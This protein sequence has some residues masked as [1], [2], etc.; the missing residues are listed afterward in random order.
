[1]TTIAVLASPPVEGCVPQLL[2]ANFDSERNRALYRSALVDVCETVQHG[3]ADLLVNYPDPD[4]VPEGVDPEQQ[5]R[6]L[7]DAELTDPDAVRYEVQVGESEAGRVGNT[8]THLL[9][10][11]EQ[12]T[13]GVV[14][15]TTS[16]LRREHIG[17]TAMQLRTS[18]VVLGPAP[19][20]R[21][22]F[23]AFTEP[24]D[25]TDAYAEPAV[26]TFTERAV[27]AGLEV[28][29]L[30]L[31]PRLD[32]D[33]GT[34]ISLIRARIR[35]GVLVPKRTASLLAEWELTADEVDI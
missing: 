32:T 7:L 2:P 10:Q 3:E 28:S 27:D 34:A 35:A 18:D 31:L 23:A 29:Y 12:P 1:M 8:L 25:F 5:L 6:E 4:T 30:P 22:W 14:E 9:D 21:L 11:E 13:A 20:G 15:P 24:I 17:T 33:L 26:E 16:L 19:D